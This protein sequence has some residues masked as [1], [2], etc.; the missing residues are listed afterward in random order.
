M[1]DKITIIEGP[2]PTFEYCSANWAE[3]ICET[4]DPE[5]I[6]TTNLR[7]MNG[8]G[9][10][11]RCHNTWSQRDTM[12]LHYR[13][14]MGL[15]ARVPIIAAEMMETEEGQTIMLWVLMPQDLRR[16]V[17]IQDDDSEE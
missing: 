4:S 5:E 10:V 3:S 17:Y 6:M 1:D 11:E 9:L 15:E 16:H 7:T 14:T 13:D 12:Y 2:T 8:R